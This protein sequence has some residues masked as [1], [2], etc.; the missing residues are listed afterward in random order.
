MAELHTID[1][2]NVFGK[3]PSIRSQVV[4]LQNRADAVAK[5]ASKVSPEVEGTG[6]PAGETN[7][8]LSNDGKKEMQRQLTL[9]GRLVDAIQQKGKNE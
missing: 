2:K 7:K 5:T 8:V 9:L 6:D 3:I 1:P 4:T